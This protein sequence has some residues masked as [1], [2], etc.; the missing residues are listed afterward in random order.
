MTRYSIEPKEKIL[1]KSYGFLCF[2]RNIR[3]NIGKNIN[4]NLSS[5]YSE[6][7]AKDVNNLLQMYLKL[8]Q[9][10]QFIKQQK[11]LVI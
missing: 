1:V 5:K 7:L 2:A 6:K 4:K 3:E 11:Q 8:V 9:K 10:E